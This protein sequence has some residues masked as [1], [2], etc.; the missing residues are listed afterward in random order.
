MQREP[1]RFCRDCRHISVPRYGGR[2][3]YTRATCQH[4][5]TGVEH[6]DLVSGVCFREAWSCAFARGKEPCGPEGKLWQP[7]EEADAA[8]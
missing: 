1:T 7:K 5:E 4:E 8:A 6:V 3:D 2:A